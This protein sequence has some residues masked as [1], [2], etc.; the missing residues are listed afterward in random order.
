M[1]NPDN[2]TQHIY[3]YGSQHN[4]P[5]DIVDKIVLNFAK[6]CDIYLT[7]IY[8]SQTNKEYFYELSHLSL[9]EMR[10]H[11]FILTS[12]NKWIERLFKK[13]KK[14]LEGKIAPRLQKQWG[15]SMADIH[16]EV[17]LNLLTDWVQ[18][19]YDMAN[20]GIDII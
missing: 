20:Q 15:I 12:L 6:R 19:H 16:P 2:P 1:I 14:F 9:E 18:G 17:I 7:E 10:Q 13:E 5:K 4:V 3:L 11:G 8:S